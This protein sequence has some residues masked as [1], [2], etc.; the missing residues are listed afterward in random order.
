MNKER[1]YICFY[2]DRRVELHAASSYEA[3]QRAA[4]ML[5]VPAKKAYQVT[6]MLADVQ[7]TADF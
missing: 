6:P 2:N 3:Q 1:P 5:K 7:H 4:A